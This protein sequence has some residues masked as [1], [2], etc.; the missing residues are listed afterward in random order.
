MLCPNSSPDGQVSDGGVIVV[1]KGKPFE[2]RVRLDEV[3]NLVSCTV[4]LKKTASPPGQWWRD[5]SAVLSG[6]L[7]SAPARG[8]RTVSPKSS[9]QVVPIANIEMKMPLKH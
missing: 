5:H 9:S 8:G 7:G 6:A 3:L 4:E 1:F 2:H